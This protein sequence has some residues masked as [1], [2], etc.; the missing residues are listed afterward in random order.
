MGQAEPTRSLNQNPCHL[1]E[2]RFSNP[3]VRPDP[4]FGPRFTFYGSGVITSTLA[5][6]AAWPFV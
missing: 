5:Q 3:K 2:F 4:V 1:G 6:K